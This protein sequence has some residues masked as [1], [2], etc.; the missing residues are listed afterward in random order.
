MILDIL[1]EGRLAVATQEFSMVDFNLNE[2]QKQIQ[3]LAREFATR[4]VS[5][6][7]AHHDQ[8]GEFPREICQ[9][10]FDQGLMNVHIPVEF[11]GL[12]LGVFDACLI[13]EEIASGCTGIGTA[14]EAN[15]LAAAPVIVAGSAEQKKTFLTPL[16]EQ[17]TFAAYCVTEPAAGSD[18]AGIK[19]TARREG[20]EYVLNGQK[21]WIT[22]AGV[23]SWLYVLAYTD[24]SQGH[25][26][27]TAFA[28]PADAAGV[29]LGKKEQNMGQRAS[30]TRAI[31]FEDVVV[32]ARNRLGNEG[33]GF[34]I[35]MAAFDHTRP[36]VASAAVG[37][38][39]S[40]M[41]HA[42][43]YSQERE[44]FGKP[45]ASNQAIS[46]MLADMDQNISAARLLCWHAAWLIDQGARNTREAARAKAFAADTAMK[47]ATDAVQIFGGY[48]YSREY[49][50][51][52][53]MRD[54]KI[55]QIYEGTSQ[56]QRIIIARHLMGE[57]KVPAVAR[58]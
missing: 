55:F 31:T 34:K 39:R 58:T 20:D 42:V 53:L 51:E 46:F 15:N 57:A 33:E 5:P 7:A 8:T 28:V 48:G 35:S 19:T 10:A 3:Q 26:G 44:A 45:I 1:Q 49:P 18:V 12:G 50:V 52:K 37:L 22:N 2:E 23:A 32:P 14:M 47:V 38:A 54:A 9:Q 6:K 30:D 36:L 27:M 17:L 25:K 40:A 21:M 16:T 29:I 11:G 56:I 4:V 41:E 24:I 43:R 13:A